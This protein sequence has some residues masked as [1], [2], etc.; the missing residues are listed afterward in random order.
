[1]LRSRG[2]L[3]RRSAAIAVVLHRDHPLAP[4]PAL[5]LAD[6]TNERFSVIA[7]D[8]LRGQPFGIHGLCQRTGFQA[9]RFAEVHDV[10]MQLAMIAAGLSVGVPAEWVVAV[11][12]CGPAALYALHSAQQ[13][14]QRV[15]AVAGSMV[16]ARGRVIRR[17]RSR[18]GWS[19]IRLRPD[20]AAAGRTTTA[21]WPTGSCSCSCSCFLFRSGMPWRDMPERFGHREAVPEYDRCQLRPFRFS[22]VCRPAFSERWG[23]ARRV[24]VSR[25]CAGCLRRR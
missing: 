12:K 2:W 18:R 23:R 10:T 21:R 16:S 9:R 15:G 17:T 14:Q 5:D 3:G 22:A 24:P 7:R 19:G 6:L 11:P 8:A 20:S 4:R 25:L 1:M 13:Q